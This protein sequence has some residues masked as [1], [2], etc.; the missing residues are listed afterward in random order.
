MRIF[1]H[2]QDIGD[3]SVALQEAQEVKRDRS[4]VTKR[5]CS[6]S[7]IIRSAHASPRRRQP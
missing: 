1:Q 5:R 7:S 3:L 2:V 6:Y 4:A